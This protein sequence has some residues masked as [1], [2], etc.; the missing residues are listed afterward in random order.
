MFTAG[1][2]GASVS[3]H[4][5]CSFFGLHFGVWL[6]ICATEVSLVK[7]AC[8]N[9]CMCQGQHPGRSLYYIHTAAPS[10][11]W[12][13]Q[14][15]LVLHCGACLLG[16]TAVRVMQL[17]LLLCSGC[18]AVCADST[19]PLQCCT[20]S[21]VWRGCHL[22]IKTRCCTQ[23]PS[24]SDNGAAVGATTCRGRKVRALGRQLRSHGVTV[25]GILPGLVRAQMRW[26]IFHVGPPAGKPCKL[27]LCFS[28]VSSHC[29]ST[30]FTGVL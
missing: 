7:H 25:P 28:I 24:N 20:A 10:S 15:A 16:Y 8:K 18:R 14:A 6:T 4:A 1:C 11:A 19:L 26:D 29:T 23:R 5:G 21:G 12:L 2:L 17:G 22:C 9:C 3:S 13:W 27:L 30:S